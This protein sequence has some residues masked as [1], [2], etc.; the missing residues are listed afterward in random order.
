MIRFRI[1]YQ[2]ARIDLASGYR[3]TDPAYWDSRAQRVRMDYPGEKDGPSVDRINWGLDRLDADVS[4]TFAYFEH[5]GIVPTPEAFRNKLENLPSASRQAPAADFFSCLERFVRESAVKNSWSVATCNKFKNLRD[6][7]QAFRPDL[8][9]SDLDETCL[10]DLV[11][12]WRDRKKLGNSSIDKKLAY[13]RWF[14]NWATDRE[15]NKTMAYRTFRASKKQPA[16]KVIYLTR[17]ELLLLYKYKIP[18]HYRYLEKVRDLLFF[19]CFSGLRHSDAIN[20]RRSDVRKGC[21]EVTTV[22]TTDNLSIELNR[23]TRYILDKYKDAGFPDN[24]ALPTVCNQTMNRNLKTLCRLA[25]IDEPIRQ[26]VYRGNQRID[27]VRPKYELIGT[28]TGRRT[29]I[30]QSLSLGVPPNVVMK[31]TG[32]SDYKS[33]KPYIDIADDVKARQ[34]S[35]LDNL[36]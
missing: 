6:D 8:T 2:G 1:T 35:K 26:T 34:M 11:S 36:L 33:M 22:K 9:F 24:R 19:C 18:S 7:L 5:R 21:I 27:T 29:F 30:V 15:Y 14:L 28:H 25:G 10:L 17:E 20:L 3:I 23:A 31:W 12:F 32:H 4:S 13:L 16:K